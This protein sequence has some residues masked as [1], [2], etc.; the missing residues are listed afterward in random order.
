MDV[1]NAFLNGDVQEEVFVRQPPGF[2][3]PKYPNKVYKF[4]KALYEL[5]QAT[6]AWYDRLKTF[7]IEHAYMTRSIDKTVFTLNHGNDFLLVQ[8]YVDDI[9]FASSS[10]TL[11]SNFQEMIENEFQMSIMAELTFFLGMQVKQTKHAT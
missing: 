3:N 9:T 2:K 11:V 4:S 1:K 8:I 6:R 5:K 10:H 7:L